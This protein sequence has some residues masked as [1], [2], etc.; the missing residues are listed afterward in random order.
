MDVHVLW[1]SVFN[2]PCFYGYP[3]E[4][5]W[6]YININA[7]TCWI[8]DPGIHG[9]KGR[10]WNFVGYCM[11]IAGYKILE[12][13]LNYIEVLVDPLRDTVNADVSRVYTLQIKE[14]VR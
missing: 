12:Y 2:Y 4:Y 1:I 8:L 6:I 5:P 9:S 14:L 10:V 3:F 13:T 11:P 7:L